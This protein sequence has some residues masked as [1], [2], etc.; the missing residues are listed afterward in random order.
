MILSDTQILE[1]LRAGDIR[2]HPEICLE[3]QLQPASVDL[4]LACSFRVFNPTRYAVFDPFSM[5][6]EEITELVEVKEGNP[7]IV[8][9]GEFVL[10]CTVE[11]LWLS[12]KYVGRVE[13]R[14]SLGRIGIII[15]STAGYIDPGF[16]GTVTLEISNVGKIPVALYPGM[17][18]CQ[19]SFLETGKVA[20]PYGV[21]RASKYQGQKGPTPSRISLD[22]E[23]KKEP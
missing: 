15:H 23:F 9:P 3:T 17:R 19:V 5:S 22:Q 20:R 12:P 2:F 10:G 7:F 11:Y 8:H 16:E 14:S 13:G 1:A 6:L 21:G 4:R 18:I